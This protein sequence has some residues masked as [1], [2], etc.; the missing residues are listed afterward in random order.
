MVKKV[1]CRLKENRNLVPCRKNPYRNPARTVKTKTKN[2]LAVIIVITF[3]VLLFVGLIY[4]FQSGQL[5][6]FIQ[7]LI[8]G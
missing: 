1:D 6:V 5:S 8:G 7:K 2:I 4:G 3:M